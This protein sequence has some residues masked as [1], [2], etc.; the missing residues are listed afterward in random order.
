[1]KVEF[2]D[3][4]SEAEETLRQMKRKS[5]TCGVKQRINSGR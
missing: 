2:E 3:V 1:M 5:R 4:R